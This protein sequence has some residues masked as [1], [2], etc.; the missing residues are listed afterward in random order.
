M[1]S[2]CKQCQNGGAFSDTLWVAENFLVLARDPRFHC[3]RVGMGARTYFFFSMW[4]CQSWAFVIPP[5]LRFS[6]AVIPLPPPT[7][8]NTPC[9]P[10]F[11]CP[12]NSHWK[13][14]ESIF[15][16]CLFPSLFFL[17]YC[18]CRWGM[19]AETVCGMFIRCV[20]WG[21]LLVARRER[22]GI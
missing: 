6:K 20:L 8:P 22:G 15:I 5:H 11:P 16:P 17:L 21:S 19:E 12:R 1:L 9:A 3:T 2:L 7:H 4:P 13:F 18:C 14:S 10:L